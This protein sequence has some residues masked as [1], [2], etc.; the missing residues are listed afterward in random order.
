MGGLGGW[1]EG[2]GDELPGV[3]MGL[4]GL[5]DTAADLLPGFVGDFGAADGGAPLTVPRCEGFGVVLH[6]GV[7][8]LLGGVRSGC[9][10]WG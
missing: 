4:E 5:G 3:W 1:G 8:C 2:S 6:T 9:V 7:D 10:V